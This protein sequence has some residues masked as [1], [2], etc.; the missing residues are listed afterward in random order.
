LDGASSQYS[1]GLNVTIGKIAIAIFVFVFCAIGV[2][3]LYGAL[4]K[5]QE[6]E[7]MTAVFMLVGALVFGGFGLGILALTTVSLSAQAKEEALKTAHPEEPWLWREDWM[8]G[9]VCSTGKANAWFLAGFATLWNLI[10]I[11]M[12]ILLR[13]EL[14]EKG[15]AVA[16][17]GLLFPLVG[18]GVIVAAVRKVIQQNKFGECTFELAR[19]PGVLGG[20]VTGTIVVPRGLSTGVALDINLSCIRR[21]RS[22][23][24]KNSSTTD[25]V[26]WQA[27]QASAHLAPMLDG[28][29]QGAAVR[30]SVPY[31]ASPTCQIDSDTRVFWRLAAGADIP[32]VDFATEFEIP[33]F[34]TQASSSSITEEQIRAVDV[35][36]D[37]STGLTPDQVGVEIVSSALGGKEFILRPQQNARGTVPGILFTLVFSG[38]TVLLMLGGAPV[39]IT[40]IF[41][42]FS[43]FFIAALLFGLFGESRVIMEEK[44]LTVRNTL[45]SFQTSKTIPCASIAKIGI[46]GD[47][48]SGKQGSY[49]ITF[50]RS[51][52]STVS[53]FQSLKERNH[54]DW[55]AEE[56]RKTM[57]PWRGRITA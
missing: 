55:L 5:Y 23:S 16:L 22:G 46:K 8:K 36:A 30:F 41:G 27:D 42:L 9:R 18:I 49:S 37:L 4:N 20:D 57:E 6:G 51:D 39:L 12:V 26:L 7:T 56:M 10:C 52:G 45:F 14:F 24:G 54:A 47:G 53:P 28:S 17:I 38:I 25:T 15:N 32:G 1:T 19:V 50:T 44:N 29:V 31:D 34:K 33:V 35:A 40:F 48:Q 2:G 43:V 13:D 11:P 3:L 21:H